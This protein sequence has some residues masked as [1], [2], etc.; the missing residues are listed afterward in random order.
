MFLIRQEPLDILDDQF[1]YFDE[2][3]TIES[4]T[5]LNGHIPNLESINRYVLTVEDGGDLIFEDF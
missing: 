1:V 5:G 2:K 4:F 3:N